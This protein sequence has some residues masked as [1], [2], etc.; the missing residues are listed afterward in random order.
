[1]T[2]V[3]VPILGGFDLPPALLGR[4]QAMGDRMPDHQDA[5][6]GQSPLAWGFQMLA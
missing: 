1:M 5:E 6:P 4:L 3:A 2:L